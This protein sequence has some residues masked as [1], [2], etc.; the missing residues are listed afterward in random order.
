M[1]IIF[2][3]LRRIYLFLQKKLNK[4]AKRK[5]EKFNSANTINGPQ[6]A[7]DIIYEALISD[8][9]IMIG[10][11]GATELSCLANYLRV[12]GEKKYWSFIKGEDLGWW[13]D[14]RI[15]RQM[16]VN[17]GFY[18]ATINNV[19]KFCELMINDIPELDIMGSWLIHE[20]LF[21]VSLENTHKLCFELLS[22]YFALKPWTQ[23]LEGKN[24]L[25][26]HPFA[27]TIEKQYEKRHLLFEKPILPFFKLKT[28]KAIQ[29][30]AGNT[31]EFE[32]WFDAL[33]YMKNEID[34][35]D[36]DICLIGCGAYGFPLAAHV[37][38][39]GKKAVH[40]GGSLQLLFGIRGKR[41][42]DP[43]YHGTYNYAALMNDYW[44]KASEEETPPNANR[45]E[46]S[47][48]W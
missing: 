43:N 2:K 28:I 12:K 37:K 22:P 39:R 48:Y 21:S 9:P 46:E 29:T 11:F 4:N 10:R 36:Y 27:K 35:M 44:V 18:P 31:S 5:H 25:V 38:R 41:W 8:K 26:V 3:I 24:V 34:K 7:S 32:T 23:A 47:C 15:L 6:K 13:W 19:E 42:E 17:A 20:K 14:E 1:K 45:V 40:L 16:H 33:D 30:I